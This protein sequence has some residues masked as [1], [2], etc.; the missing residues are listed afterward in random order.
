MIKFNNALIEATDCLISVFEELY[1]NKDATIGFV[2]FSVEDSDGCSFLS[3][4]LFPEDGI[5]PEIYISLQAPMETLPELI[6][7]EL[8]HVVI[9]NDSSHDDDWDLVFGRIYTSYIMKNTM[10]IISLDDE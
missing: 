1:P 10:S 4:T 6:A 3:Y 2:E 8:A 7:H 9:G 5:I